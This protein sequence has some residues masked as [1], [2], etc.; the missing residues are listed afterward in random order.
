MGVARILSRAELGL[1]APPVQVEAH[2]ANGLPAFT[3]VGLPAPVVRESRERVRAALTN[4]GFDF[5]QRRI[6]VNLA[7]V[8]LAKHGGR[9]DLPIA[10][11]L[12]V[13]SGQLS[14]QAGN[15]VE[16]YGELGLDG[17]LRAVAGLFLA[18]VHAGR[19]G[20]AMLV[21]RANVPEVALAAPAAA[22]AAASLRE[23]AQLL[24]GLGQ[25]GSLAT[26]IAA[27]HPAV[28][29]LPK[30]MS[31]A[32]RLS[33][34]VGQQQAKRALQIAASGAHG[35]L[36]IG[37]PGSGKSMLAARLPGLLPALSREEAFEVAAVRAAA[38]LSPEPV[39]FV[40][41]PFRSPHHTSSAQAMVGGGPLLRPGEISLA[42]HGVLFLDELP[43][44]DR[45]VLEALREPLENGRIGLA[46][47]ARRLELP[48]R[49]QLIAAMNPCPCGY[50]GDPSIDCRCSRTRLEQYRQ[51]L[52]GPLLDRI[53]MRVRV[54]RL[55]TSDLL[56]AAGAST[57]TGGAPREADAGRSAP[58]ALS[59]AA[60]QRSIEAA[61][62]W[63]LVRSGALSA[64]LSAAELRD[65]CQLSVAA[66]GLLR[67]S[68]QRWA[69]SGR[70]VQRLLALSRTIADLAASE[71]V[72]AAH[73]AE[74]LQLRRT[75]ELQ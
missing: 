6:T 8:E 19:D 1:A 10:L 45:R 66:V 35:V 24:Q 25:Y 64:H 14:L 65:C 63:R 40:E 47:A 4:S 5:P 3:I 59:D 46:R 31:A 56:Q 57:V 23:A 39:H 72:E 52:S 60:L 43:E 21:P 28:S 41:R 20:H 73:L 12:L 32:A 55:P 2:L 67:Q 30:A 51:R 74:A 42:H 69:L 26:P 68:C 37:P 44:F 7:P 38:G 54:E 18:A 17:E 70:G 50:L 9:F 36:L 58:D 75:F 29:P 71:P 34:V 13:A 22:Y 53:D 16:C 11:G 61:R 62:R 15:A 33:D 27:L 48:A 49:F